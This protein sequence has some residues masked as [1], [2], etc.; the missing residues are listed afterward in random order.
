MD[1]ILI[2]ILSLFL[3]LISDNVLA[4]GELVARKKDILEVKSNDLSFV[5]T[6]AEQDSGQ[7]VMKIPNGGIGGINV[8]A[9]IAYKLYV[10]AGQN[11]YEEN[12][13]RLRLFNNAYNMVLPTDLSISRA[14]GPLQGKD[15]LKVTGDANFISDGIGVEV[16]TVET[17]EIRASMRASRESNIRTKG[18]NY[19]LAVGYVPQNLS[20]GIYEGQ[21]KVTVV[22]Q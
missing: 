11:S 3:N 4:V 20:P 13:S 17:Q 21:I 5:I 7:V 10:Q 8:K 9:N 16:D 15:F 2:F 6:L 12:G 18:Q 19:N 22:S 14:E 1:K